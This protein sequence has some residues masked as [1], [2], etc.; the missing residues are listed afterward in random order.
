MENHRVLFFILW[1][2]FVTFTW[3][4]FTN[5][6]RRLEVDGAHGRVGRRISLL[7]IVKGLQQRPIATVA[8]EV[9]TQGRDL[10]GQS[11]HERMMLA[12]MGHLEDQLESWK[13]A[14]KTLE[15][16]MAQQSATAKSLQDLQAKA[17][18]DE[19]VAAM[20]WWDCKMLVC[21]LVSMGLG[22][23]IYNSCRSATKLSSPNEADTAQP[24][25]RK[26][27]P[28][29][30]FVEKDAKPQAEDAFPT[31]PLT[32]PAV[33]P[34]LEKATV[35]HRAEEALRADAWNA[36]EH[37]EASMQNANSDKTGCQHFHLGDEEPATTKHCVSPE[38]DWWGETASY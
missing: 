23:C 21:L 6:P 29:P 24:K 26:F 3:A 16:Q 8:S 9:Q 15:Q 18:H 28:S 14:S 10:R 1:L 31:L 13:E 36:Q 17:I 27:R 34:D 19:Q 22:F 25:V 32:H 2:Q 20:V 4:A 37:V 12:D 30:E 38:E 33:I 11:A 5:Q 7:E 35:S